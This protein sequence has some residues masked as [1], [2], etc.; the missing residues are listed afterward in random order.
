M[1]EK[2]TP[3]APGITIRPDRVT[4]YLDTATKLPDRIFKV[5]Y[6]ED[7]AVWEIDGYRIGPREAPDSAPELHWTFHITCPKCKNNLLLDSKKKKI[8]IDPDGIQT[9]AFRCSHPGMFGGICGFT[10]VLERP[11]KR[12]DRVVLVQGVQHR[13]DAI[14]R[15]G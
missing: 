13:I 12:E 15:K 9:E 1:S 3:P 14:V 2:W 4:G 5:L 7:D 11:S 10:F 8:E 6:R